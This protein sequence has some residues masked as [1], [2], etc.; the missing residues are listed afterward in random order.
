M[1]VIGRRPL[2]EVCTVVSGGTPKRSVRDYWEGGDIPWVKISDLG[3]GE[4]YR[5]EESITR[6]GLE[7]SAAKLLLPGTVLVSIFA[8]IGATSVIAVPACT[9]QAI[10]GVTP[11][12]SSKLTS[13]YIY[14]WLQSQRQF[15]EG[16]ARGVAQN[17]INLSVLRA[18]EIPLYSRQEQ[19]LIV[20]VLTG[21]DTLLSG[22]RKISKE[23]D[24]LVKSRFI[25][26]FGDYNLAPQKGEWTSISSVGI[27]VGG[28]TPK[29][30]VDAYWG[31]NAV[32]IT[33][34]ELKDGNVYVDDSARK[35]TPEGIKSASLTLMPRNTV[36][37]SSRAP[38]GK[39]AIANCELYCNQGFKNIICGDALVPR[40]LYELLRF[41]SDFLNSLGKGATFK[42]ISKKTVEEIRIPIPSISRQREFESFISQVDKLRF[43]VQQQI[44]KLE[45]LKK[46]LMQEYFG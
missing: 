43:D 12:A 46:S 28:A 31:G 30:K 5:T 19:G 38:I 24:K 16:V 22:C 34:A 10:A 23:L 44:E 14:Y 20:D 27:V 2:G 42:E 11:K 37:L 26:M 8:T 21:V 17:N 6:K 4:L 7:N 9:N 41:N 25:E 3:Q 1:K 15:M 45:I 39:V 13:R 29:T 40:Y 35:L 33:P 32:W 18:M 36:I